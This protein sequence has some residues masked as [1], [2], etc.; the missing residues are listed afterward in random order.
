MPRRGVAGGLDAALDDQPPDGAHRPARH[1]VADEH[2]VLPARLQHVV[3][4]LR[5]FRRVGPR[6]LLKA[7]TAGVRYT[8][9]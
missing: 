9:K 5:G 2:L 7:I 4:V 6:R 1:R 8:G 3:P